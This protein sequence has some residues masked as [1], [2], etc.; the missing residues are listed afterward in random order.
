MG[1]V[2]CTCAWPLTG[3]HWGPC[4]ASRL[5]STAGATGLFGWRWSRAGAAQ[6]AHVQQGQNTG[7]GQLASDPTTV[8]LAAGCSLGLWKQWVCHRVGAL[9]AGWTRSILDWCRCFGW[10]GEPLPHGWKNLWT[11]GSCLG[12]CQD[13]PP[14]CLLHLAG[15]GACLPA[16]PAAVVVAGGAHVLGQAEVPA[17]DGA[18]DSWC[19]LVITAGPGVHAQCLWTCTTLVRG[20]AAPLA[21]SAVA[22]RNAHA[23][24]QLHDGACWWSQ[25][26]LDF[27]RGACQPA[28]P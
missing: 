26:D 13:S 25:Q 1:A 12:C 27:L 4:V 28:P 20:K 23:L 17:G 10:V 9:P 18:F 5:Q 19:L 6:S 8:C 2:L 7:E 3:V 24:G 15:R 11:L 14:P 22:A 21:S 16:W